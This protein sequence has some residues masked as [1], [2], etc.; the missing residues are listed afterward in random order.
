MANTNVDSRTLLDNLQYAVEQYE[1]ELEQAEGNVA[2]AER[3]R[4]DIRKR[5]QSYTDLLKYENDRLGKPLNGDNPY[6]GQSLR[7]AALRIIKRKA[8]E[9]VKFERIISELTPWG[10]FAGKPYP[11][12][13]L[14]GALMRATEVEKV[15]QGTYRWAGEERIGE[16]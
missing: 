12:R 13:S 5:L 3:T 14:H 8:P 1:K 10:F 4:D 6:A 2:A 15:D 16:R 9:P 7:D 11:S